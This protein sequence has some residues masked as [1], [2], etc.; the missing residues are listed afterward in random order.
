[1]IRTFQPEVI[2]KASSFTLAPAQVRSGTIFTNRGA[3]G[4]VTI[5]LPQLSNLPI[6]R[7][8][9]VDF[10]GVADQAIAFACTADTAIALNDATA[11]SLTAGTSSKKIGAHLRAQWDGVAWMLS[12]IEQASASTVA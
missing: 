2:A 12:Q 6:W 7:G 11:T 10:K 8:Y 3:G 4:A 9:Y 1:M 5:T